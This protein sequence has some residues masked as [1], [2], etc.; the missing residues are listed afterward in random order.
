MAVAVGVFYLSFGL[1]YR[2]YLKHLESSRNKKSRFLGWKRSLSGVFDNIFLR[3]PVQRSIFHFYGKTLKSSMFHRMRL[4]SFI[5]VAVAIIL[6][7]LLP[8][9]KDLDTLLG[10]NSAMLSLPLI[11]SFFLIMGL[12]GIVNIPVNLEANWVF[13]LTEVRKRRHYF[14]GMR[15]GIIFLNL[16]PL[17][18]LIFTLSTFLWGWKLALYHSLFSIAVAILVMEVFFVHYCK[19]P[20]GCSYLPGKEKLQLYWIIYILGFLAYVNLFVWLEV[21]L[22]RVPSQFDRFFIAVFAIILGIRFYQW[23]FYYR[24][25]TVK[26]EEE[27][28]PVMVGLDYKVPLY[29]R[30][31][32]EV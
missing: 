23:T 17:F 32:H 13:Q 21:Y 8:Q 28:E 10:I 6:I 31:A 7:R 14:S 3:N 26:Y 27:P 24:N 18:T 30:K 15:K 29:K 16:L 22:L 1:N 20:F 11:L 5:T 25:I 2:R 4:T 9:G 19:I 12:R